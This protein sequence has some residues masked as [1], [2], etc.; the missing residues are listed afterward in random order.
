MGNT[1]LREHEKSFASGLNFFK[2]FWIFYI[3][4]LGGVI[5]E[6]IWCRVTNG[7]FENRTALILTP[8]NPV[9]GFGALLITLLLIK[10]KN[11]HLII[12][13]LFSAILGGVFE[14]CCSLFQ[15]LVFGTV[16][17]MYHEDSLGIFE[18]TSLVYCLYWGVLG[19]VWI[20]FVYPKLSSLIEKIPNR[21]GKILT[22][23]LLILFV[24]DTIYTSGAVLRQNQRRNN[25]PAANFIDRFY[26]KHYTD[27]VLKKVYPHM[28]PVR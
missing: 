2:M 22:Y 10:I 3:G 7:F 27:D 12:L 28:T 21:I 9:Y 4:C 15:E 26:D 25:I 13:F 17:W 14:Y 6:T 16:S 23:I 24:L 1:E 5:V 8:L 19:I 18:R 20:K 11:K